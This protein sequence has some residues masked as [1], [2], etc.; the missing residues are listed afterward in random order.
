MTFPTKRFYVNTATVTDPFTNKFT[1]TG[2]C[3]PFTFTYFNREEAGQTAAGGDFSPLPPGT[4]AATL[5]WESTVLSIRSGLA[6]QPTG[7]VSGVLGSVNTTAINL[8]G[9]FQNGWANLRFTGN[10]A[11]N[12]AAGLLATAGTTT[13]VSSG[14]PTSVVPQRYFG[15]PVVG[16]MA[17]TFNNGTLTCAGSTCQGNYGSLF[18][19]NFADNITPAP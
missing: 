7:S 14:A 5:C 12:A 18:N 1:S 15:L 16:F 9:G 13:N 3:E 8:S 11:I 10:A 2:S 4:A 17:R 6:N 19:H